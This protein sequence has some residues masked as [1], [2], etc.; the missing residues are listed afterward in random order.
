MSLST[1]RCGL[2]LGLLCCAA[3]LL[4]TPSLR[5][6]HAAPEPS[7]KGD[8]A[9]EEKGWFDGF[10]DDDGNVVGL[11]TAGSGVIGGLGVCALVA[12]SP[13][14][15][16]LPLGFPI[17]AITTG[18]GAAVAAAVMSD[19]SCGQLWLPALAGTF[20][21]ATTGLFASISGIIVFTMAGAAMGVS[22]FDPAT[23]TASTLLLVGIAGGASMVVA[24]LGSALTG[25][26][27]KFLFDLTVDRPSQRSDPPRRRSP[28]PR[29]SKQSQMPR[30]PSTGHAVAY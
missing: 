21:G 14:C 1:H 12:L 23:A 8:P 5:A 28:K 24:V 27:V 30:S 18:A 17:A 9:V 26:L 15:C 11:I 7:S 4:A 16:A 25:A 13:T 19:W 22:T 2:H 10:L 20:L 29:R 6:Q 3:T